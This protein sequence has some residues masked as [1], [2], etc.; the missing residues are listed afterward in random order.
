[1]NKQE[2]IQQNN[3]PQPAQLS[4]GKQVLG[5]SWQ[6]LT[7]L[8]AK[9]M[10]TP[11]TGEIM[12]KKLLWGIGGGL[13][14]HF[15]GMS[16]IGSLATAMTGMVFNQNLQGIGSSIMDLFQGKIG[17]ANKSVLGPLIG[18]AAGFGI[19]AF[20]LNGGF[21]P[22]L[23]TGIGTACV[24]DHVLGNQK[25]RQQ[26]AEKSLGLSNDGQKTTE[27]VD[28]PEESQ[29]HSQSQEVA[30][31]LDQRLTNQRAATENLSDKE[32]LSIERS[33][34]QE[35]M[36]RFEGKPSHGQTAQVTTPKTENAIL[37]DNN[38]VKIGMG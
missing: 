28:K 8:C 21:L 30:K 18:G 38:R 7:G 5:K 29:K 19:S 26:Q 33:S 10:N 32:L 13:L 25:N 1:M 17:F 36:N 20:M 37:P 31:K 23:L 14:G 4:T 12:G 3:P 2:N 9:T 35:S 15:S 11:L 16:F 6:L 27:K 24:T 34:P 22:S